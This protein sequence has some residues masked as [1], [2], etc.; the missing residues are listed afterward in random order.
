[1][2]TYETQPLAI[3]N[4]GGASASEVHEFSEMI[5]RSVKEKTGIV[6]QYEVSF[7]RKNDT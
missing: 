6:L 5:R 3:V 1:V 7:I 4:Y 2:G